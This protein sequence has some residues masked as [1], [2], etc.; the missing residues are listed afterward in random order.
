MKNLKHIFA[1][2]SSNKVFF[3]EGRSVDL[4]YERGLHIFSHQNLVL[5][6]LILGDKY[7]FQ[8]KNKILPDLA[9]F[10]TTRMIHVKCSFATVYLRNQNLNY[11]NY[12]SHIFIIRE[13]PSS[14]IR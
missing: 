7:I 6:K 4:D 3:K 10:L 8:R 13:G 5:G 9:M 12:C 2:S 1:N 11:V 14:S